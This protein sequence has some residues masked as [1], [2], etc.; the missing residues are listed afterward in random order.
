MNKVRVECD[1]AA[2]IDISEMLPFQEDIK[3]LHK[4]DY[5]SLKSAICND[6]FSEP[7]GV[8]KHDGK[9]FVISGH[10]R[11][12]TLKKMQEEGFE[13]PKIP[14]SLI[15]CKDKKAA[16]KKILELASVYGTFDK[17]KVGAFI[18][19]N[20]LDIDDLSLDIKLP[21]V[22]LSSVLESFIFQEPDPFDLSDIEETK[23]TKNMKTHSSHVKMLQL[24]FN[25]SN[26]E[27]VLK[28]CD[29]LANHFKT[30]NITDTIEKCVRDCDE[31]YCS[32]SNS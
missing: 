21:E 6:G 27:E 14:V 32:K 3:Y 31:R 22:D 7:I 1:G 25:D 20:D 8:W 4:A 15:N 9:H 29:S 13:I 12:S 24:F 28:M 5:E 19:E 17:H 2:R 11:L 10:Q 23:L 26:H 18:K 30:E 16:K